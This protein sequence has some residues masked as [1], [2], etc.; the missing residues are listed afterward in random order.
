MPKE[1]DERQQAVVGRAGIPGKRMAIAQ[2][3]IEVARRAAERERWR[4]EQVEEQR[5]DFFQMNKALREDLDRA[6]RDNEGLSDELT[7]LTHT[8][9]RFRKKCVC[10]EAWPC[11]TLPEQPAPE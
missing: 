9:K 2:Q 5:D 4:K 8:K 11:P 1:T 10:G 7:R 3:E 6:M